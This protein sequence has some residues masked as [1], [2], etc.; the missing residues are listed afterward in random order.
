MRAALQDWFAIVQ[1]QHV[2]ATAVASSHGTSIKD[3]FTSS[4]EESDAHL[5]DC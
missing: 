5:Q 3:G 1:M 4:R 2:C